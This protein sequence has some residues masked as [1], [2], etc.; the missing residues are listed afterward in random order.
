MITKIAQYYITQELLPALARSKTG[1]IIGTIAEGVAALTKV[2][3]LL[4]LIQ[5]IDNFSSQWLYTA[6]VLWITSAALSSLASWSIHKAE[7][8]FSSQLRRQI[9]QHLV[10]LPH[11]ALTQYSDNQLRRLTTEDINALHHM[12]AHLPSEFVT[13]MVVPLASITIMIHF[14][15]ATALLV[16]LPGLLAS[17]YYL[18]FLP[19]YAAKHGKRRM[20]IMGEI[21]TAVNDY[22]RGIKI[23]RI[24]ETHVGAMADYNKAT[25]CFTNGIVGWVSKVAL[26]AAIAVALLQ[27]VATFSIA[28]T[29]SYQLPVPE[30]AAI[31]FF[32]LAIVTPVLKLGHGLDYV[33][34]GK[35]AARRLQSFLKE[36]PIKKAQ[37]T[38]DTVE[39]LHARNIHAIYERTLLIDNVSHT[40]TPGSCTAIMGPSGV[41]KST[42]LRILSGSEIPTKGSVFLG[43]TPIQQLNE[44]SQFSAIRYLPQQVSI[45]N[46]TVRSNLQLANSEV[47]ER[48][49]IEALDIAQ[50]SID[51]EDNAGALSGGQKQRIALACLLLTD[52]N[53]FLLDEPTSALDKHTAIS[54]IE[55][56]RTFAH[57]KNKTLIIVTHDSELAQKTD[58]KLTLTRTNRTWSE[59]I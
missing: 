25:Q 45:L 8:Q 55:N 20:S 6:I 4:C 24:F 58:V 59:A 28:Y 43:E 52:A 27:A 42:F 30:M 53:I 35:S 50:I 21:V 54:V 13:F 48:Q 26:P 16:L 11:K 3:A 18:I 19:N 33:V 39:Q 1:L 40:F 7:A 44:K 47:T 56:L 49:M 10:R 36:S 15:G 17:L 51:L 32:S 37:A 22:I 29:V 38:V 5:L 23:N 2:F 34:A 9:A 57:E 12:V 14:A 31:F 41:G 46:T